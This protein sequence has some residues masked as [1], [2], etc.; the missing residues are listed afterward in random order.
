MHLE[1]GTFR[2]FYCYTLCHYRYKLILSISQFETY[3]Q[4]F[5]NN[6]SLIFLTFFEMKKEHEHND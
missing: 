1:K 6:R 4:Y 5:H 3:R 2:Q